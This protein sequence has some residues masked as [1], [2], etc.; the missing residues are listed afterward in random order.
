MRVFLA[1]VPV[2]LLFG[3]HSDP[4]TPPTL[5]IE[6]EQETEVENPVPGPR[7]LEF[8]GVQAV[9]FRRDEDQRENPGGFSFELRTA[10]EKTAVVACRGFL[11]ASPFASTP[12]FYG[13]VVDTAE[14]KSKIL[15]YAFMKPARIELASG[16]KLDLDFDLFEDNQSNPEGKSTNARCLKD[17]EEIGRLI[18]DPT[19]TCSVEPDFPEEMRIAVAGTLA[20]FYFNIMEHRSR[21]ARSR[22]R[23]SD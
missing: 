14:K 4:R 9:N 1:A 10:G 5:P 11:V 3:G 18:I 7:R 15:P 17:G 2:L 23:S 22:S 21:R 8:S 6:S 13:N 16:E 20:G 19:V 12:L